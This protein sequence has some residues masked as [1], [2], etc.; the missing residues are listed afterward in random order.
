MRCRAPSGHHSPW[1]R[2]ITY[3]GQ[4]CRGAAHYGL[5]NNSEIFSAT[6]FTLC[7]PYYSYSTCCISAG[8]TIQAAGRQIRLRSVRL[9]S[10]LRPTSWSVGW[11]R[12]RHGALSRRHAAALLGAAKAATGPDTRHTALFGSAPLP[13]RGVS[14]PI[15]VGDRVF[16]TCDTADLGVHRQGRRAHSSGFA[17]I[18]SSR[19]AERRGSHVRFCF[20]ARSALV[21]RPIER[22]QRRSGR[23]TGISQLPHAATSR[24]SAWRRSFDEESRDIEKKKIQTELNAIRQE[25][26]RPLSVAAGRLWLLH[27]DAGQRWP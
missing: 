19:R 4:S 3:A 9:T 21:G 5:P 11:A 26:I 27:G 10:N 6:P 23:G 20:H 1:P 16:V 18:R 12:R 7:A 13:D 24:A 15:V 8:L 14:S 22:S 17:R 2:R 25:T